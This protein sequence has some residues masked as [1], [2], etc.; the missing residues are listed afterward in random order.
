LGEKAE[1]LYVGSTLEDGGS[2]DAGPPL[3]APVVFSPFA[4][5]L[6]WDWIVSAA[7]AVGSRPG[8]TVI[9]ADWEAAARH[10]IVKRYA[11]PT[12]DWRGYLEARE[13]LALLGRARV[14]LAPF[15]D[16][17]TGRRT[18]ALAAGSVGAVVVTSRGHLFDPS[19]EGGPFVVAA[20]EE[21]FCELAVRWHGVRPAAVEREARVAWYRERLGARRLDERL[22]AELAGREVAA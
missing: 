15:A 1:L 22:W 10:P 7:R 18:S 16:G 12:W 20:T 19:L 3:V 14:V 6:A 8:L 9:G 5:G 13:V 4:A 11:D 21:E 2:G 17:L